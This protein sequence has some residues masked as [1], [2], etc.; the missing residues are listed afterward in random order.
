MKNIFFSSISFCFPILLLAQQPFGKEPL[1]HTYSIVAIDPETGEMGAA[2]QSHWFS[3][4][5]LV[6]WG[7]PGVG[8][9]AT[10]SFVNPAYGPEG[11]QL[12]GMGFNPEQVIKMLTDKDDGQMYR[13]VGMLNADGEAAAFTGESCIEA[14]GH[15]VGDGYAVQANLMEKATV[16]PAMA[17]AF[18]NS[19]GQPLAERLVLALEAAQAEGGDIR[20]KQS[21]A[22]IIVS[23]QRTDKAW[24]GRPVNLRVDDHSNP[25]QELKRLLKVHRAYE[26]MNR[27]DLAV[28]AGDIDKAREE[29]GAAEVM[30]PDN[31]EMKYWHALAL[32]NGGELE[33]ALPM[34]K[35]I[36]L[37]DAN[38]KVLTPRLSKN[39]LLTV[40]E[41][42]LERIM[43]VDE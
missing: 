24:E 19:K 37:K 34:F 4:G 29:Y 10:Q 23:G 35:E 43:E 5:T 30:F 40:D 3:V 26:H 33:A 32:A 13:Q 41:K 42:G 2:V 28:E 20:G 17:K 38:W 11:L 14:A 7:E 16:W 12:M 21:A 18:E 31:L 9:V 6:I 22:L 27:G 1:A 8:V 15:Y 25:V 36:F 39:G